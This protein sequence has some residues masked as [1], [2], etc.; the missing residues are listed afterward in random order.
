[1]AERIVRQLVDDVDGSEIPD[2]G[3]ERI[4]FSLRG[5]EYQIDLSSANVTKLNKA[6]K[7]YVDAATKVRSSRER[8]SKRPGSH[9]GSA[10]DERAA[11]RVWARKHGHEVADRGRISADIVEAFEASR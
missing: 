7:P 10:K 4:Q 1:M 3:G 6:L 5:V 9:D 2:G 11:I 8:R